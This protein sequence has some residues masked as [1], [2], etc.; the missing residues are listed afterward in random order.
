MKHH[1]KMLWLT[2]KDFLAAFSD[3]V[4][5]IAHANHQAWTPHDGLVV[6]GGVVR[7][8]GKHVIIGE[9]LRQVSILM[10]KHNSFN[11]LTS[12]MFTWPGE[13]TEILEDK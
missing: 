4:G 11:P 6:I 13:M 10:R 7:G 9:D 2:T 12:A 3:V 1:K 5:G 8:N